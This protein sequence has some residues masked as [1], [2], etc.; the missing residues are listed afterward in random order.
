MGSI[1]A[2]AWWACILRLQLPVKPPGGELDNANAYG[3]LSTELVRSQLCHVSRRTLRRILG[4][5][6]CNLEQ[7]TKLNVKL[8]YLV[9]KGT[10]YIGNSV[11]LREETLF[12]FHDVIFLKFTKNEWNK[13]RTIPCGM[14]T[15]DPH[16]SI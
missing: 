15:V 7:C 8:S 3:W 10:Y 12:V 5:K 13:Q 4:Y 16:N 2:N 14:R 9:E 6:V 11:R 1:Q